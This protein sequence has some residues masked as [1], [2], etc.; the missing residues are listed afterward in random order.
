MR[1]ILAL[2]LV[3]AVAGCT[4]P[5][6]EPASNSAQ[7]TSSLAAPAPSSSPSAVATTTPATTGVVWP[8]R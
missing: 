4:A 6:D 5:V 2:V 7:T 8:F 3:A 1:T